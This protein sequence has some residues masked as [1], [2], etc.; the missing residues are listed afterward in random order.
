MKLLKNFLAIIVIF[1]NLLSCTP[2]TL[3]EEIES[4]PLELATGDDSHTV[5]E[6]EKEDED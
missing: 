5:D 1:A 3:R 2:E 4:T 6:T